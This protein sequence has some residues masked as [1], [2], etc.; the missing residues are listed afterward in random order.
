MVSSTFRLP[1]DVW[2]RG[3]VRT[4]EYCWYYGRE[5]VPTSNVGSGGARNEG[6]VVGLWSYN[7]QLPILYNEGG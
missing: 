7:D 2:W 6:D 4:V 5:I 3:V 1:L